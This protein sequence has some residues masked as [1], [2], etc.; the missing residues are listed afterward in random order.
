MARCCES[1]QGALKLTRLIIEDR[2]QRKEIGCDV[3]VI[4]PL[5]PIF[6][7]VILSLIIYLIRL[8]DG[9]LFLFLTDGYLFDY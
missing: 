6:D 9:S 8:I 7:L 1:T 5:L 3:D 4:L 2:K